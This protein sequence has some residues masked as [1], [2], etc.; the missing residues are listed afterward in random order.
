MKR[1]L[2]LLIAL[3]ATLQVL[4]SQEPTYILQRETFKPGIISISFSPDGEMLLAGFVDGSFQVLD[5]LSFQSTLEVKDAH[6]KPVTALQMT[7][8]MDYILTAGAKTIKRWDRAGNLKGMY[9]GH[10]TTIW[11]LDVSKDGKSAV[12]TA[13]NKT[14]ILW[15][16]KTRT[17][18]AHMRGHEDVCLTACISDNN[19]LIASGSNDLT[20]KIWDL[21]SREVITT[22]HGPTDDIYNVAF[23]PDSR[24]VA[25][26]SAEKS[27]RIYNIEEKK[28]VHI[29]K[30]HRDVVR[31]VDF[32]PDGTFLVSASEDN[33]LMLWET[34]SG[35]RIFHFTDNEGPILDV[36]FHPDGK[37]FYSVSSLGELT[38]WEMNPEIIVLHY[39]ETPYRSELSAD[40]IFEARRNGESRKDYEARQKTAAQNKTEILERYYKQYLEEHAGSSAAQ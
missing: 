13:F 12:S 18:I 37:S 19:K 7:P 22:F 20:V 28:L 33:S 34:K 16:V 5:P 2:L 35:E 4:V 23:S 36:K 1:S 26:A 15:D 25:A 9:N 40:P 14:F 38:R 3:I 39:Y 6:T 17:T 11:N 30:G 32:S 21:E 27:I 29:L 31:K 24:L 10:A 8:K